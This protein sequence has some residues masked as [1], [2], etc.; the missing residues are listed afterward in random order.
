MLSV[1]RYSLRHTTAPST[2]VAIG[3]PRKTLLSRGGVLHLLNCL[4]FIV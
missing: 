4:P 2:M 3:P 1:P